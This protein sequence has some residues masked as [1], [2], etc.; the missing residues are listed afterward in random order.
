M[1]G[2]SVRQKAGSRPS[3]ASRRVKAEK[4]PELSSECTPL[5][6]L[7]ALMNDRNQPPMRSQAI[8]RAIAPYF[9]AKLK[10]VDA[11]SLFAPTSAADKKATESEKASDSRLLREQIRQ[12]IFSSGY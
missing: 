5:E 2:F 7:L 8:A 12:K 10:P 6:R 1:T 11:E 9:H 4:L 3:Q